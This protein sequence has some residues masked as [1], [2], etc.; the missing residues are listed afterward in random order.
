MT[1]D[2]CFRC[3]KSG[4]VVRLLDAI[5]GNEV[6]KICEECALL[7]DIPIIR[8]PN[9]FQLKEAEK[10]YTVQERLAR[11][12]GVNRSRTEIA[13]LKKEEK[14]SG[15]TLDNLRKPKDY[16]EVLKQREERARKRNVPLDLVENYNWMIQRARRARKISLIQLGSTIGESEVTLKMIEDGFLP[17]DAGRVIEKIGQFFKINLRKTQQQQEQDRINKVRA[18]ARVLNFNPKSLNDLTIHDLKKLKEARARMEQEDREIASKV[19]WQGKNRGEREME[20]KQM[21]NQTPPSIDNGESVEEKKSR[22]SFWDIFKRKKT[23]SEVAN[24]G[25]IVGSDSSEIETK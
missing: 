18:P 21:E 10:P 9:S 12:S 15:I 24:E 17:D 20:N 7:E 3:S 1:E 25:V 5:Y 19:V 8:K 16:S 23:D 14:V 11:M 2:R 13:G 4:K 22:K 6:S